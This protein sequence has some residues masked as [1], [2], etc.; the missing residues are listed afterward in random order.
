MVTLSAVL[1]LP[2][3]ILP[4]VILPYTISIA[5]LQQ[6]TYGKRTLIHFAAVSEEGSDEGFE[7][8]I[9]LLTTHSEL[10]KR[11]L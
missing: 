3:V 10:V 7:K 2:V 9:E 1:V 11:P 4:V 6:K 8:L 5:D